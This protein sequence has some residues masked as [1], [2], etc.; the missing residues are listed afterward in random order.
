MLVPSGG[1]PAVGPGSQPSPIRL[2]ASERSFQPRQR[3]PS[4]R[5]LR[6]LGAWMGALICGS[7]TLSNL[8]ACNPILTLS[9]FFR[10]AVASSHPDPS[11]WRHECR[12]QELRQLPADRSERV[13]HTLVEQRELFERVVLRALLAASGSKRTIV[14]VRVDWSSTG[15]LSVVSA[16][17]SSNPMIFDAPLGV[18]FF[19]ATKVDGSSICR[20]VSSD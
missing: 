19:F 6:I 10:R 7:E 3:S 15:G 8:G 18:F 13:S 16:G 1:G 17:L 5:H 4:S 9:H 12:G 2:E 20:S 11:P 14:L